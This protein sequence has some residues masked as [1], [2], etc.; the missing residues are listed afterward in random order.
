VVTNFTSNTVSFLRN[1]GC[2][3]NTLAV[4]PETGALRLSLAEPYPNPARDQ[5]T[6]RFVL[7]EARTVE[8]AAYDIAGR[9]V[10][11]LA[12]RRVLPAGPQVLRWDLRTGEG[13]ALPG[14]MYLIRVR[15]GDEVIAAR[16]MRVR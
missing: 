1:T 10:A 14:G 7:P 12:P 3:F 9:R 8:V 16:V 5:V 2:G 11:T 15:A 13:V 4:E 6:I